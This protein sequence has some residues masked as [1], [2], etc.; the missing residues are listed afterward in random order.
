MTDRNKIYQDILKE[1]RTQLDPNLVNNKIFAGLMETYAQVCTDEVVL[2]QFINDNGTT[3]DDPISGV[4]KPHNEFTQLRYVRNSKFQLGKELFK[5]KH[6]PK[7]GSKF[8][9]LTKGKG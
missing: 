3:Y 6:D 2:Q 5:F 7:K 1:L 9:D 8:G 4:P